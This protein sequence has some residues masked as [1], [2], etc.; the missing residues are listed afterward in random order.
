VSIA[1]F[2]GSSFPP[3][4]STNTSIS[5][6][7]ASLVGSLYQDICEKLCLPLA[8]LVSLAHTA[9]TSIGRPIRFAMA[10]P[11]TNNK[12][13][14]PQPTVPRPA[15]PSFKGSEDRWEL[16]I[17]Y[18]NKTF[19]MR[20]GLGRLGLSCSHIDVV[21]SFCESGNYIALHRLLPV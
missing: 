21:R 13:R 5:G 18:F 2:A 14:T 17:Q 11:C 12:S 3:M 8:F 15:I 20:L 7:L 6:A 10:G 16:F 1:I 9:A 19:I 4:S